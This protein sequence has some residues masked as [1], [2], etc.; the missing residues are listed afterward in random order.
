MIKVRKT[1]TD[2]EHYPRVDHDWSWMVYSIKRGYR[3][4]SKGM[5]KDFY[6][7]H[8]EAYH[9]FKRIFIAIKNKDFTK[10][11]SVTEYWIKQ[12]VYGKKKCLSCK[13]KIIHDGW[14]KGCEAEVG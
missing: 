3:C 1:I 8:R 13:R 2:G 11:H 5:I 4:L 9:H 14:C 7:A 6:Y 12:D 10:N